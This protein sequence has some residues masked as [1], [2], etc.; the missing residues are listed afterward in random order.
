MAND[1]NINI[2][3]LINDF[4]QYAKI[5]GVDYE[6]DCCLPL[7]FN[8]DTN[9]IKLK[10][11]LACKLDRYD[12]PHLDYNMGEIAKRFANDMHNSNIVNMHFA[13]T[14][15]TNNCYYIYSPIII[16]YKIM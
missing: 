6:V 11:V 9:T 15:K 10:M 14:E 5:I 3:R 1:I 4:N 7:D 16:D 12:Y 2:E 13:I 8:K